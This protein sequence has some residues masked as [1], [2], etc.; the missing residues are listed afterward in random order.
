MPGDGGGYL[1]LNENDYQSE[2]DRQS[3]PVENVLRGVSGGEGYCRSDSS[4]P[5]RDC[6]SSSRS[7]RIRRTPGYLHDYVT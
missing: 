1:F 4:S 5:G 7:K 6:I 3:Q 2:R